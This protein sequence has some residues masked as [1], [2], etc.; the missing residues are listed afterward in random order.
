MKFFSKLMKLKWLFITHKTI[1][2][3]NQIVNKSD[4]K[5]VFSIL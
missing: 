5:F 2:I 3:P 1:L 4:L